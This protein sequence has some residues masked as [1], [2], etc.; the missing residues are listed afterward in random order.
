MAR[1]NNQGIRLRNSS[2]RCKI[3][4]GGKE[5]II[6][7]RFLRVVLKMEIQPERSSPSPME[8]KETHVEGKIAAKQNSEK[9]IVCPFSGSF[10]G[11]R[12]SGNVRE[13]PYMPGE[14]FWNQGVNIQTQSKESIRRWRCDD[15]CTKL[16]RFMESNLEKINLLVQRPLSDPFFRYERNF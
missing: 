5:T 16:Y 15:P 9:S 14:R 4:C 10:R 11:R 7:V 1:T 12:R 6:L 8:V 3:P 2:L 13:C